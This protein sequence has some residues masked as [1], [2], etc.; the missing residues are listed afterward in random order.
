MI[1]PVFSLLF[2]VFF[3]VFWGGAALKKIIQPSWFKA[4]LIDYG[5]FPRAI[6]P[7]LVF[8]VPALEFLIAIAFI[9]APIVGVFASVLL[10]T[11]YALVLTFNALRG[12]AVADCGCS[13]GGG[14]EETDM[15]SPKFFITRNIVLA[16]AGLLVLIP[17]NSRALGAIDWVNIGLAILAFAGITMAMGMVLKNRTHMKGVYHG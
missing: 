12:H 4:V 8:L 15:V 7:P 16:L 9:F 10:L 2:T 14:H 5:I 11:V 6:I 1:D 3:V 13:W 17:V